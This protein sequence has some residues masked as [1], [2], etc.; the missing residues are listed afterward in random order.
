MPSTVIERVQVSENPS[1]TFARGFYLLVDTVALLTRYVILPKDVSS[2]HTK[3][4]TKIKK[5]E[6]YAVFEA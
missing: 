4:K 5:T 2:S 3:T 6:Y 1:R